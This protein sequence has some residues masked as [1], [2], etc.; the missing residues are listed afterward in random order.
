MGLIYGCKTKIFLYVLT[1]DGIVTKYHT[2]YRKRL[3]VSDRIVEAYIQPVTLKKTLENISLEYRRRGDINVPENG[4][5][6]GLSP[7]LFSGATEAISQIQKKT[8][9]FK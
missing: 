8:L 5:E 9:S 7:Y 1:W 4:G 3:D 2:K 6:P